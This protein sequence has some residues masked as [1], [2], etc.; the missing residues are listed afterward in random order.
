MSM[1]RES[2]SSEKTKHTLGDYIKITIKK[3]IKTK[4]L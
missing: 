2:A 1:E 4:F 3:T